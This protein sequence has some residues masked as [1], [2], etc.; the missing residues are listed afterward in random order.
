MA[1]QIVA[2]DT[3]DEQ[4]VSSETDARPVGREHRSGRT[5]GDVLGT[6]KKVVEF[7]E[8]EEFRKQMEVEA[9]KTQRTRERL[10][11][12]LLYLRETK[13]RLDEET[14]SV[15]RSRDSW[16]TAT[17]TVTSSMAV[18]L[19][20]PSSVRGELDFPI[21]ARGDRWSE[22][23][24]ASYLSVYVEP[25]T[26]ITPGVA[27]YHPVLSTGI[28]DLTL[29]RSAGG[30]GTDSV[31]KCTNSV[32][33]CAGSVTT[34]QQSVYVVSRSVA[35]AQSVGSTPTVLTASSQATAG[36]VVTSVQTSD[37]SATVR[38]TAA[39]STGD[40]GAGADL[41]RTARP[42]PMTQEESLQA[43][44]TR[45]ETTLS[46][47]SGKGEAASR[48]DTPS[49][50]SESKSSH[51]SASRDTTDRGRRERRKSR[52]RDVESS[53]SESEPEAASLTGA[54]A[55]VKKHP[56]VK[57]LPEYDGVNMPLKRFLHKFN[58]CA[59][60]YQWDKEDRRFFLV[61]SL[62]GVPADI[63]S[64][65]G[66]DM[67]EK[68]IVR[69]LKL[70]FGS[71]SRN[72]AYRT[73]LENLRQTPGQSIQDLYNEV[74]RLLSLSY[75]GIDVNRNETVESIGCNAFFRAL[76]DQELSK[77]L[78]VQDPEGLAETFTIT[79]KLEPIYKATVEKVISAGSIEESGRKAVRA[80]EADDLEAD[81]QAQLKRA[82]KEAMDQRKSAESWRAKAYQN[83]TRSTTESSPTQSSQSGAVASAAIG[84]QAPQVVPVMISPASQGSSMSP[85]T[86]LV[87]QQLQYGYSSQ[88]GTPFQYMPS[89]Q[90]VYDYQMYQ[91]GQQQSQQRG[92]RGGRGRGGAGRGRG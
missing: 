54:A 51:R 30:S 63:A 6:R 7:Q 23:P 49:R 92:Y 64:D 78:Q 48:S 39:V 44:I 60:H 27:A 86:P 66:D 32:T 42:Q 70:L 84:S 67:T 10:E 5:T 57:G 31:V 1:D 45:L 37:N 77:N 88:S 16:D 29:I 38:S 40:S 3:I 73:Q 59:I 61:S 87:Y 85:S 68:E 53:S 46:G 91:L 12:E 26:D 22:R 47:L 18:E 56:N 72:R 15:N 65:G 62:V 82:Q 20:T 19:G 43:L 4:G 52:R 90:M 36:G 71:A 34:A 80:V 55:V 17:R 83:T 11:K 81:L 2:A 79:L 8:G 28:P 21:R 24:L 74:T 25:S 76:A 50:R 41:Q 89:A 13:K 69:E 58:S 35:D 33:N 75:P 9:E 14:D